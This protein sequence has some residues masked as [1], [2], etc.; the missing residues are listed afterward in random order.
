MIKN[1]HFWLNNFVKWISGCGCPGDG[2]YFIW[3]ADGSPFLTNISW[4]D[5]W[6][7]DNHYLSKFI[8]SSLTNID[9]WVYWF[10]I[11]WSDA[12]LYNIQECS[13]TF[14]A[15]EFVTKFINNTNNCSDLDDWFY[16]IE[17]TWCN[18]SYWFIFESLSCNIWDLTWLSSND[19]TCWDVSLSRDEVPWA[20]FYNVS[21]IDRLLPT[22]WSSYISFDWVDTNTTLNNRYGWAYVLT[23]GSLVTWKV[24]TGLSWNWVDTYAN[25]WPVNLANK[26]FSISFWYYSTKATWVSNVILTQWVYWTSTAL[27]IWRRWSNWKMS[28]AFY[29]NDLDSTAD[30]LNNTRY[31]ITLTF[32]SISKI[33]RMYINWVL[34]NQRIAPL[35]Y[36]WTGN[37]NLCSGAWLFPWSEFWWILDELAIWWN[38]AISSEE[39]LQLY[40]WWVWIYFDQT[41]LIS[42]T[43]TT[44]NISI[45]YSYNWTKSFSV[46][47]WSFAWSWEASSIDVNMVNCAITSLSSWWYIYWDLTLTWDIDPSATYYT[48]SYWATVTTVTDPTITIPFT[49]WWNVTYQVQS[50]NWSWCSVA[51]SITVLML[52]STVTGISSSWYTCWDLTLTWTPVVWASWYIVTGW[53]FSWSTSSTSIVVPFI[54]SWSVTYNVSA[55]NVNGQNTGWNISVAMTSCWITWLTNNWYTCWDLT[56]DWNDVPWA[57]SYSVSYWTTVSTVTPSTIVIPYATSWSV[58]Y[59]VRSFSGS[60]QLSSA[61]ITVEM[62]SCIVP[63]VYALSNSMQII[64]SDNV[65]SPLTNTTA[66]DVIWSWEISWFTWTMNPIR[67]EQNPYTKAL[68]YMT[69]SW[70][71]VWQVWIKSVTL[72]SSLTTLSKPAYTNNWFTWYLDIATGRFYKWDDNNLWTII[73]EIYESWDP[74]FDIDCNANGSVLMWIR[75][76]GI[77]SFY[78]SWWVWTW[79]AWASSWSSSYTWNKSIRCDKISWYFYFLSDREGLWYYF[80]RAWTTSTS[81]IRIDNNWR[82]GNTVCAPFSEIETFSVYNQDIFYTTKA[83]WLEAWW[84]TSSSWW[85]AIMD[86]QN[87]A[88][89]L[90]KDSPFSSIHNIIPLNSTT[91]NNT[92]LDT[93]WSSRF[94]LS[95]VINRSIECAPDWYAYICWIWSLFHSNWSISFSWAIIMKVDLN[96]WYLSAV[97]PVTHWY[98]SSLCS[99]S[100]LRKWQVFRK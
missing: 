3:I 61:N 30:I 65:S 81:S 95:R 15:N 14:T 86:M 87:H 24:W 27:H 12:M 57:T 93:S 82:W 84:S 97:T 43:S 66:I 42:K 59:V 62:A 39:V 71:Y 47:W 44:N 68:H 70:L 11:S 13:P 56:L 8:A 28:F 54:S 77:S 100:N 23:N 5:L 41:W 88:G 85:Y 58:E 32:D 76:Y 73:T 29:S 34:D 98:P 2:I 94:Q 89:I 38:R 67:I 78:T 40:N 21:W 63:N 37:L 55:T 60:T 45:P 99:W 17:I 64:S 52:Q 31:H 9:D 35:N 6:Y 72:V 49:S 83:I 90:R 10:M 51:T 50:C 80:Y 69:T 75:K 74:Y 22:G 48:V 18:A 25:L 79:V 16:G 20:Q 4:D 91:V 53:W 92:I 36:L 19:Y 7:S 46:S 33:Q 1:T 96:W 26:S